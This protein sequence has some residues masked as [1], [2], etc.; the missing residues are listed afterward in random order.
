MSG[1]HRV[2]GTLQDL[3]TVETLP[4]SDDEPGK[5]NNSKETFL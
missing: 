2:Y 4:D 3:L 5:K 1:Y